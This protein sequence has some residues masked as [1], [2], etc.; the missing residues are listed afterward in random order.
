[1]KPNR[2]GVALSMLAAGTLMLS[3]CGSDENTSRDQAAPQAAGPLG[4]CVAPTA[5]ARRR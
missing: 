4:M 3:A 1:M 2:F 5:V